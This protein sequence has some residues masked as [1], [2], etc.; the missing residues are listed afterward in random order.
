MTY[1]AEQLMGRGRFS[2]ALVALERE[3][4]LGR[5]PLASD[6]IRGQLLERLGSYKE[7]RE[8]CRR[9]LESR[10]LTPRHRGTCEL[11]LGVLLA[12]EGNTDLGVEHMRR[13]L[14]IAESIQDLGLATWSRLRLLTACALSPQ[15]HAVSSLL[16]PIRRDTTRLGDPILSAALHITM[17]ELEAQRGLMSAA[18]RHIELGSALLEVDENLWLSARAHNARAAIAIMNADYASAGLSAECAQACAGEGGAASALFA[19]LCNRGFIAYHTGHFSEAIGFF[20]K[21][22]VTSCHGESANGAL[23]SLALVRLAQGRLDEAAAYINAIDA[24]VLTDRDRRLYSNRCACLTRALVEFAKSDYAGA[25]ISLAAALEL[26]SASGDRLLEFRATLAT[27]ELLQRTGNL[28]Q[29]VATL[30]R[31]GPSLASFP[32]DIYA[33]YEQVVGAALEGEGSTYSARQHLERSR[34]ILA[35]LQNAVGVIDLDRTLTN[36][37]P[38]RYREDSSSEQTD[39]A[40]GATSMLQEIAALLM[41]AQ[42][43]E[44]VATGLVSILSKTAGLHTARAVAR[45]DKGDVEVLSSYATCDPSGLDGYLEQTLAVG[46]SRGRMIEVVV[47]ARRSVESVASMNA[48]HQFLST[49]GLISSAIRDRAERS[50]LWPVDEMPLD[51]STGIVGGR[52]REVMSLARRVAT[53]SVGVLLTGESGTGKEVMAR[54]IHDLSP[55]SKKAFVPFNCTAVPR[56][57][58]ESQLFGHRRGAF[59]GADRDFPGL[60]RSAKEGTLFLD[61]IGELG[62]DLQ[63]KLLRFLES[64]EICPLGEPH[65]IKIEV[66]VIAA[67]NRDL[68]QLVREGQF[69]EDLYYRLNIVRLF[70]PPLRE[71][72]DEIPALAHH[73]VAKAAAEF[74]KGRVRVT[75]DMMSVLT[76]YDWPGNV[77]QLQNELR[78]AVALA[79]PDEPLGSSCLSAEVRRSAPVDLRQSGA[80]GQVA[81]PL[82]GQLGPTIARVETEMIRLALEAHHG[83][84]DAA[85]RS[86]G[87]SR[88]GLYLKRQRLGI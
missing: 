38:S 18:L 49:V 73:F 72:R 69:R 57:L 85:A 82:I 88:K 61:E 75:E 21:A 8:L 63:P 42:R 65:P 81:V 9:L 80:D 43:P 70:I 86:L 79:D 41:H 87:I 56:E 30:E 32:P 78:R 83:R 60:I 17:G 10:R 76:L 71:R 23:D 27:A 15:H 68:E 28:E 3:P 84:L 11:V 52:M 35:G 54:A 14:V 62:L 31:L 7:S 37:A 39:P 36:N 20:E 47:G 64:G 13:A 51:D 4:A 53:T 44:I 77:R 29:C 34:L 40:L 2:E 22:R 25:A 67:T 58:L 74:S 5:D 1:T 45:S 16:C 50:T 6:V 33:R 55:R 26:A 12:Y 19:A 66:R 24:S 59:T 46:S 48:V